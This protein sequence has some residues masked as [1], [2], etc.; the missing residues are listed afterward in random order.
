[1]AQR[2]AVEAVEGVA[3]VLGLQPR[4]LAHQRRLLRQRGAVGR[5]PKHTVYCVL[6]WMARSD[7]F[8]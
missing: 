3:E 4:H 6:S 1:M 5:C 8:Q 2:V 7:G